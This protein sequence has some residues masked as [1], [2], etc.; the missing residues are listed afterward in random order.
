MRKTYLLVFSDSF[1]TREQV[2]AALETMPIIEKWRYDMMP[3]FYLVS[4]ASAD[5]IASELM[6][7]IP[8]RGR[9]IVAEVN[10]NKQ[11]WLTP[12]SWHLMNTHEYLPE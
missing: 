3:A 4:T 2:K 5:L 6:S 1:G 7:R 10:I 8:T 12:G 9:F 11:G